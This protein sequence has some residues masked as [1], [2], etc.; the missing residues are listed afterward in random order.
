MKNLANF[1]N[2]YSLQKTLRFELKPIGKTLDWIIKKDLLKQ[3]EI[4]AEDYKIVKKI[5]DRYHKD[6]IDLAFESAYL[7]KKSSDSFT[8]IME[9]SIQSYSELYF[10]KEKSDR[11]KKAMEEISGIMRKEIVECFTGKY[12]EVV[13]KKFGNLFKKELIKED[14]LNFCEPDELPII[15]K[16][17]DFTTYF[18]GFHENRENMYSN[19]EK[20][21]AIANRLIRENLPRYL[22]N[23]RI[24]RSI[25]GRYKDFGWKDLESNLKRIDKN[26]QYSDFLTENGF[27]YTFS[28]KGIDRYNLIL[29]G[30]SVES[31]EKIQGLNELINLYRQKNQLDRRQLPNLK[32]L[33][34]QILSDRTRHSFVPE[35][36]S[37]DKALLRSL[38]DFH[39]EVIQNKNLFEEKQVSLL[40]AIRETLTDLKSFDLDR[41]YLTNDTSLTQISNFVFGDWSKVK[42][43]LAIYFDENIANPKDRQRQSNSYLKA[44]ENWLKKNYYSIHEL[45]EAISVYGKHSD[46]ELPNTKIEDYF[47]G[48]Q[49][50]D[51]T[52][53][54]ID[55]LD[56]IV[57]KYADLESLLTK[58]Y[59]EDKNLKSD[60][61]SIEKIKNYLDSIKLLQN[62]LKPLKPKKV[63]DEKDLGFYN[64]LELY[65]E[66]LESANSLYNKVRNYLTG[67]EYSD[68][69]IKLN[70][71]NSTLLDGWDENKETSNLSVIFR[72]TNNYY[73]GILD[74]QNN[75]IFESIPEIQSGE[76]TIQKMV[77][78]LLPGANN[79]LPKVFFS[80]KGL[81]KFN[82]SDEITSLYSEGRFKKGDK[83]SINSLHTLIDFYKKSLAVHEDWSVFNFK[84]DE[85][86]HYEDI[87][88]FYRQVESQGYKITFKPISKKY[89][90]TLVED[91]KLYLFQIYNKDFSQNKKGGGKP[92]LHT[93]YFK[94]LFEKENLKDVIV[95]LNGQA[96]VFFRKK[97][98]HY[99]ENI[100]RY[101]HHSELLKGRFSYP[102]LK[103][104][105]FTE[106][107]FQ[108]HFPI[109]L[110]FKSGEIKQFNARVNS[111]LKHNK[112]V[113]IIGIDRGERHLL[114]LSLIDQDGKILRQESLN[115]IKNDQNFKAINYQEKLHK[116]EI[117]RDQA[118][119][120]WGSIENIKELKEGYLSQ[121]VH[122]I[123]KLMVEHNAIVVL[124]DL[125]F[126]FKRG[127]QKVERQVYQKFEKMLIE[128]LN[129]LVFKDKEMD[130][131]GGILKAYQLT[132]NFVSFEKMGKQTGFVFYVPAWN[133][134]K[135]DP[136][137][138]FVNF[139]H[140]NYENVNQAKELI[141]KFDQIRYNQDRD[142]F[143]F[144][145]TTDQFFTKENA[146]DTRTWIICSTPTKRF[147]SKR[148]VNGSVST[149]EIDVNQ[150][151]KELFNDCNYQDG[152]DLVD[153]ILEKD[154]KDFFS[155]LIAYLRILTSLRQNNGEQGFE[156]RDF[157]L[158]PVVGSDG[159]FFNSLD[160]SSQE[161]KDADANGAYHIALK[162]LM[163]LHVINETDDESLGK[164]SWKISNK[165]WLNFVWQ[166]P[167]LKA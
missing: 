110:N 59:P 5:I 62:F 162:G 158:S 117:E 136:K 98:I 113:K 16:F 96:E 84:F 37:S 88:Q 166:R 10:I 3:D 64:D 76:E 146:P 79:M 89:I 36:F 46:E 121:V 12:S 127:R 111:Y 78:K 125:N 123:S 72:D 94:S 41:I 48:L 66:S 81:L 29:G 50:K 69:K 129:F 134:S 100:T 75:R 116:K 119:K 71:K 19:E 4:L 131:P 49:T 120:S 141:G 150:K 11:D 93:I 90:D 34:K 87:S 45:N 68:E 149:I 80:E 38:L 70:F 6:F 114:Y 9:A 83:F 143:E 156:E 58:E 61:G 73:L 124:E 92:N 144:Q 55:V 28:Q 60:K 130:E 2:L 155:K 82:P 104:K 14:L 8:A 97:S 57:S 26:L 152:E 67:K 164:P 56:A 65:L 153:R 7:Q 142:W 167:S 31:G 91:G 147:Y 103:D 33:Y 107:K 95:K 161:P 151:L 85:T 44:K 40:Q 1:T 148:T 77:Y 20:A 22:D 122:T 126:G 13:K 108:F 24:I 139:L 118:R 54:P 21:T 27:V 137:T 115:L 86:S 25:Q 43:I 47:S 74:K 109:T 51:E 132:D 163:N 23:L 102:I 39:K 53:K 112:D 145:V 160:A 63:Q 32:E 17:A 101:G 138:G 133:T 140:L 106:D 30:Q 18:T 157:I 128:K 154:S 42:T 15:Q 135:I 159:K 52:K 35:K 105:R 165:D 99:D